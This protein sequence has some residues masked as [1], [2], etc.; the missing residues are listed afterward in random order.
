MLDIAAVWL[1][2]KER[3]ASVGNEGKAIEITT[4][5]DNGDRSDI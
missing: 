5:N 2:G 1:L 4:R 3:M